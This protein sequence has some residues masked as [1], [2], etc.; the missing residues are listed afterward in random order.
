MKK[1]NNTAIIEAKQEV[2][3][4]VNKMLG[5]GMPIA[6]VDMILDLVS[7]QARITLQKQVDQE[8]AEAAAMQETLASQ[9]EWTSEETQ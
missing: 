4:V 3:D 1:I 2:F 6:V 9:V 7:S 5:N 8:K